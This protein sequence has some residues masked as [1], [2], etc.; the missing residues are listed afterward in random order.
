MALS[1]ADFKRIKQLVRGEINTAIKSNN[2][3]IFEFINE[4]NE[5]INQNMITLIKQNNKRIFQLIRD[6]NLILIDL[7]E[8]KTLKRVSQKYDPIISEH[9]VAINE[10]QEK[11][12]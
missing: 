2:S 9:S 6:N 8:G 4:N 3:K 11:A 1:E 10:L 7:I 5:V 12:D